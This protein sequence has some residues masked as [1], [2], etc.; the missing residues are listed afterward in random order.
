[1][2][3]SILL[4]I[5]MRYAVTIVTSM[6]LGAS[7]YAAHQW[8]WSEATI[9]AAGTAFIALMTVILWV[10]SQ[11]RSV[12]TLI[13]RLPVREMLLAVANATKAQVDT[14]ILKSPALADDVPSKKVIALPDPAGGN[15]PN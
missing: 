2:F 12:Q 3:Q 14:I 9:S 11:N 7:A 10:I 15:T 8:G 6:T 4:G 13:N 5:L 1:M